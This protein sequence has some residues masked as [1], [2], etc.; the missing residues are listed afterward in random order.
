MFTPGLYFTIYTTYRPKYYCDKKSHVSVTFQIITIHWTGGHSLRHQS[1]IK[2]VA[3]KT[4]SVGLC[5]TDKI[6]K[7]FTQND[8]KRNFVDTEYELSASLQV[9]IEVY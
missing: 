7:D 6:I 8:R 5:A 9:Y 2:L 1:F 4:A 3:A